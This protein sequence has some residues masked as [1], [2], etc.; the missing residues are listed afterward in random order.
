MGLLALS[1]LQRQLVKT[2]LIYLF[3]ADVVNLISRCAQ[4]LQ[5]E[6]INRLFL[7]RKQG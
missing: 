1:S 4:G 7:F 3:V 5:R 2:N 6:Q